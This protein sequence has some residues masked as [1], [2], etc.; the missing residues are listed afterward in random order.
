MK[1]ALRGDIMFRR[2][3]PRGGWRYVETATGWVAPTPMSDGFQQTVAKIRAHR[4]ANAGYQLSTDTSAIEAELMDQTAKRILNET[5]DQAEEWVVPV[6]E[7]AKKKSQFQR[8]SPVERPSPVAPV[9]QVG[10]VDRLLSRVRGIARGAATLADWLGDG[11]VPV[12]PFLAESRATICAGCPLNVK[13]DAVGAFTGAVADAIRDQT[14]AKNAVGLSTALEDRIDTCE[15]CGCHLRLKVWVPIA[16]I[17]SRMIQEDKDR[18]HG[19]CWVRQE[20]EVGV[21]SGGRRRATERTITIKRDAAFGDVILAS[22]L[23]TKLREVG[24]ASNFITSPVIADAMRGHPDVNEWMVSGMPDVD[25]DRTYEHNLERQTKDI[26]L[27]F[28]E[29]AQHPLQKLGITLNDH[30]NRVPVLGLADDEKWD[31][32]KALQKYPRPWIVVVDGS[33]SWPNRTWATAEIARLPALMPGATLI[34]SKPRKWVPA[35]DGFSPIEVR[36]FRY[37][38]AVISQCDLVIAPDTGPIHV[39]AAFNKPV[40]ALEQC[41]DTRLRLTDFTD[42]TAVAP[43]LECIRCG[44]FTCPINAATPP[45]QVIDAGTVAAMAKQKIAAY[46]GDA[47]TAIIPV[48]NYHERLL[49]CIDAIRPQVAEVVVVCDGTAA[50]PNTV[51]DRMVRL[52]ANSGARVGYGASLMRAARRTT[53]RWLMMLNDDCYMDPDAVQKMLSVAGAGVGVVGC[54]LRY[55]NGR[56]Q[57]AGQGRGHGIVGFGHIDHNK[58]EGSITEPM[59]VESVTFAA[60]LVRREMFFGVRGFDGRYDC[61]SEDTD[62]CL[63]SITNGWRVVYQPNATG[64]HDESQSTSPMKEKLLASGNEIFR[65]KWSNYLSTTKPI[66]VHG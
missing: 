57:H 2:W 39:A 50:V 49:R 59:D 44:E 46:T 33:A 48:L 34:W 12:S 65:S 5:P 52:V 36:S 3:P 64:I 47:V 10:L 63:K 28:L 31:A 9:V 19:S 58:F 23:S 43:Q 17:R 35:P 22:I 16:T 54:Q 21:A 38:M 24:V 1:F 8:S 15:A 26:A 51:R 6:D 29:A 25:L 7:E 55:P 27:L 60:A 18:L 14:I 61:Y 53:G 32:A 11:C 66:I 41:N 4:T 42:Y 56:I 13:A 37:L 62:L 40:I 45:C 20:N 30:H